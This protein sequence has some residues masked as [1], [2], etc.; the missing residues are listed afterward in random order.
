MTQYIW[1]ITVMGLVS[2]GWQCRLMCQTF[3]S[4]IT[5]TK[6][7][8]SG[9]LLRSMV[10]IPPL[11]SQRFRKSVPRLIKAILED[12]QDTFF[13]FKMSPGAN[14]YFSVELICFCVCKCWRCKMHL[15]CIQDILRRGKNICRVQ[16][17]SNPKV[18]RLGFKFFLNERLHYW[19]KHVV[20]F[21][22]QPMRGQHV[23]YNNLHWELYA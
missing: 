20:Q 13:S 4:T 10:F 18:L 5:I 2:S 6:A 16:I 19:S 17:L 7:L 1:V 8:N 21:S 3:L 22:Q 14:S 12:W 9:L 11:D 15:I 23:S